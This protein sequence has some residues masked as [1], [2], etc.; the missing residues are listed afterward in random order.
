VRAP[1]RHRACIARR[2]VHGFV[3]RSVIVAIDVHILRTYRYSLFK[4]VHLTLRTG[5]AHDAL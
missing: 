4:F 5:E 1:S 3:S 2:E